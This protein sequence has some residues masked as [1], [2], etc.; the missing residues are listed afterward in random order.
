V[1]KLALLTTHHIKLV[2]PVFE[3]GLFSFH[4]EV[5]QGLVNCPRE[6]WFPA[7][8]IL[9]KVRVLW[10]ARHPVGH[11]GI[12]DLEGEGNAPVALQLGTFLVAFQ[13]GAGSPLERPGEVVSDRVVVFVTEHLG[14]QLR[15]TDALV[16]AL[17]LAADHH[18]AQVAALT[19]DLHPLLAGRLRV[20]RSLVTGRT[21]LVAT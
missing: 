11:V 5:S 4:D 1:N 18:S 8:Q 15:R 17:V 21:A 16:L 7:R 10:R 6:E 9:E 13:A 20:A 3:V 2:S 19:L 12:L 14:S